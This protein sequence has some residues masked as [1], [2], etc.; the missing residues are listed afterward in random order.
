M[1]SVVKRLIDPDI[2]HGSENKSGTSKSVFEDDFYCEEEE[3]DSLVEQV[4]ST[5]KV[6]I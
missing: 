1:T 5:S 3:S 6:C 2:I 4:S